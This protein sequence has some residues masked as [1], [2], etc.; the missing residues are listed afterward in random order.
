VNFLDGQL[1]VIEKT[2][3]IR[4]IPDF[5]TVFTNLIIMMAYDFGLPS[6]NIGEESSAFSVTEHNQVRICLAS[7]PL[8][9]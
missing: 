6:L 2:V 3:F 4:Q 7:P 5:K 9:D 1:V 8:L